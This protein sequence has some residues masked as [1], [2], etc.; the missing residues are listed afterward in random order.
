LLLKKETLSGCIS[1]AG[2]TNVLI[3]K[4]KFEKHRGA[5][6]FR[7]YRSRLDRPTF[8]ADSI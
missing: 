1:F 6:F 2:D 4:E 5:R 8:P 3:A 7:P